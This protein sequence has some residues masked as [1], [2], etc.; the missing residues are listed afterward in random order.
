MLSFLTFELVDCVS[1][2]HRWPRRVLEVLPYPK[3]V[4]FLFFHRNVLSLHVMI[5]WSDCSDGLFPP[6]AL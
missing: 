3:S 5:L 1:F 4:R 6:P 2:E